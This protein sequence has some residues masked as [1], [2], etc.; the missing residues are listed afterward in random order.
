VAEGFALQLGLL[1]L[2]ASEGSFASDTGDLVTGNATKFEYWSLAKD[3]DAFGYVYPPVKLTERQ[4]GLT[5]E[6]FLPKHEE[7]LRTAITAFIK[8][9]KPFTAKLNPDY[10]GYA[11]FDQLMRLEEW[12]IALAD[13]DEAS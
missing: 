5:P 4:K 13:K 8:G 11:D 9:R 10:P 2:I 6:E 12:Q 3:K 1:G 7:F